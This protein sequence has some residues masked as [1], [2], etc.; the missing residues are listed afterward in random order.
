MKS[1]VKL[2]TEINRDPKMVRLTWAHKGIWAALLALAGEVDVRNGDGQETGQIYS[3]EDTALIIR[4]D[5]AE[6]T[7]AVEVFLRP[8][9]EGEN[10]M[11]YE[12]NGILFITNYGKRQARPPSARPEA[13]KERK[14]QQRTR[15][16]QGSHEEVTRLRESVTPLDSDVD[17]EP[18][19]DSEVDTAPDKRARASS[20][21]N[22]VRKALEVYFVRK[23]K[24][25]APLRKTAKQRRAA[26]ERWWQPLR[27]IAELTRWDIPRGKKFIDAALIR[28]EGLT[29]SAPQS[30]VKTVEAIVAEWARG[31]AS[32]VSIEDQWLAEQG[33]GE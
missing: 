25:P 22:A 16:S 6:F 21:K 23:T 26:A 29:I 15:E 32:S 2:Y 10:G 30:I 17:S 4:C 7:E 8:T 24:L 14:R 33:D 18:D 1:W 11:L 19:S 3:I 5:I 9:A 27:R 31:R 12:Q 28:L 13:T 20:G